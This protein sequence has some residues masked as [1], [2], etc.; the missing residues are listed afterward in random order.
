MGAETL[1]RKKKLRPAPQPPV[2][3]PPLQPKPKDIEDLKPMNV[4]DKKKLN[5]IEGKSF[6]VVEPSDK[7]SEGTLNSINTNSQGMQNGQSLVNGSVTYL[8]TVID[9]EI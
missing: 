4:E 2:Q 9:Q 5:A 7:K 1:R 8:A 3:K 6:E